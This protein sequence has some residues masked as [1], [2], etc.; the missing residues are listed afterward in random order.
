MISSTKARSLGWMA[1]LATCFALVVILSVKVHAIKSEVLLAERQVIALERESLLLETEFQTR[2]SQR[3][4]AAWNA[5][6]FGYEAPRARQFLDGERQLA[7]YGQRRAPDAPAPIMLARA[8]DADMASAAKAPMR[9]PV[10]GARVTLASASSERDAGEVFSDAFGE[11]LIEA[12]P[13]RPAQAQTFD[14]KGSAE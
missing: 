4:L 6:E 5:V 14:A 9:S 8:D 11:F 2:A 13:I 12:S 3:Q 10:S 1:V 7:S